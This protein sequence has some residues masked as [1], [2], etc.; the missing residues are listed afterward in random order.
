MLYTYTPYMVLSQ[1][2]II[3]VYMLSQLVFIFILLWHGIAKVAR[4]RCMCSN[5]VWYFASPVTLSHS[6]S[7]WPHGK[8]QICWR[9]QPSIIVKELSP[10][11]FKTIWT[12]ILWVDFKCN[13]LTLNRTKFS[14][15][16]VSL[17]PTVRKYQ[18]EVCRSM[19]PSW[20]L[21]PKTS[22]V[23]V[24]LK[25]F[26]HPSGIGEWI[27][28]WQLSLGSQLWQHKCFPEVWNT[29]GSILTKSIWH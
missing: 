26:Q 3:C 16:G 18:V 25:H 13:P 5:V 22:N 17:L 23:K 9:L 27:F 14:P 7:I 12:Q 1:L 21:G 4:L 19:I 6:L 29:D 11:H 2:H 8:A 15:F 28:V 10:K 20:Y 24:E